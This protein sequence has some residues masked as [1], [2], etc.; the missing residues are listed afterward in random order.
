M[1][2]SGIII[3]TVWW[4]YPSTGFSFNK[5]PFNM[6]Y[7][8]TSPLVTIYVT[9]NISGK[10]Y[11]DNDIFIDQAYIA[12]IFVLDLFLEAISA[13]YFSRQECWAGYYTLWAQQ[14]HFDTL[15]P[16]TEVPLV[17]KEVDFLGSR[18]HKAQGGRG[19]IAHSFCK[20]IFVDRR[21][22]EG[23]LPLLF[24]V[25]TNWCGW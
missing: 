13:D 23:N 18:T 11:Q 1:T 8:V 14:W 16:L 9:C 7:A 20:P 10:C 6:K 21:N 4:K 15:S 17:A 19:K 25:A 2:F 5:V 12:L 3:N 22:I 24:T